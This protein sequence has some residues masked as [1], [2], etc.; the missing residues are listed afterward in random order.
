[1]IYDVVIIGAGPSGSHLSQLLANA[2]L[3]IALVDRINFPR[4]KLCGGLLT[5]K[6]LELLS[7]S[8]PLLNIQHFD[9][10]AAHGFYKDDLVISINF[11][12]TACTTHRYIFD[13][14]LLAAAQSKGVHAYLGN[15]LSNINFSKKEV[16]LKDGSVLKYNFLIGA[17]GVLSKVRQLI[18]LPRNKMG[19]CME[20]HVPWNHLKNSK[21]VEKG[22]IE[23][24]YGDYSQGYGWVFPTVNTVAVGVGNL[25]EGMTEREIIT[26]FHSFINKVLRNNTVKSLGAYI[27]SG[28]SV[29]LGNPEYEDI[30][31]TGDAAG[32]IDPF[33][34]E[35]IYYALLSAEM[36]AKAIL[37]EGSAYFM[38][39][40]HMQDPLTV[41]HNAISV[42]NKIYTP[43]ILRNVIASMQSVPSYSEQIIDETILTYSRTYNEAYEEIKLYG[44]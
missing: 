16:F 4:N 30:C 1:M 11:L 12:S 34:G 20:A 29:L 3:K 38:Y 27:P 5:H 37:S 19:F 36:A 21:S 25:T 41:I 2:G 24:Y 15:A 28:D 44:R 6:T 32:L 23:I 17:D 8:Y 18:D 40:Q 33:T 31:L 42:R 14:A 39:M 13:A 35:G 43:Y 9:L 10:Q 22:G 26:S 7:A